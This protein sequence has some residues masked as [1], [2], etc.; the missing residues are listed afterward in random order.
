MDSQGPP[1]PIDPGELGGRPFSFMRVVQPVL[2]KHCIRCHR[3]EEPPEGVDLTGA[4][5]E[6]FTRSYWSLCGG[7]K[8]FWGAETNPQKA[9]EAL[10][11]RFGARNQIQ[12][13]PP[14]G[15]YGARG[16][17]LIKLLRAGHHKTKLSPGELRRLGA[18]IDC[19][20]IFYGVY[21]PAEQA[22]QLAGEDVAMPA[23]Q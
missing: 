5:H 15:V 2:D 7:P 21:D 19:N 3:G 18:W 1:S 8:E 6:G 9:A 4:P 23:I 12:V 17:R 22:K 16:S 10:V 14:G 11:P 13:T 20:A